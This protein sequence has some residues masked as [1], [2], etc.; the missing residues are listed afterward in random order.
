MSTSLT[1]TWPGTDSA[2]TVAHLAAGT[3]TPTRITGPAVPLGIPSGP[4]AD[5]ARYQFDGLPENVGDLWLV[6]DEHD[7]RAEVGRLSAPVE[8]NDA[9]DCLHADARIFG[10]TRGRDVLIETAEGIRTGFSVGAEF[11]AY[12]E[13]AAGVRHVTT[14][15]ALHLGV[16]RRPAFTQA[17]GQNPAASAELTA[18]AAALSSLASTLQREVERFH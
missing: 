7:D 10:T 14:W 8:L 15:T 1:L 5:G 6:V 11:D 13:D 16:V 17:A 9:G 18:A 4:S 12:T 3:D 2:A